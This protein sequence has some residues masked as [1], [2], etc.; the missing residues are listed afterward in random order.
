MEFGS[1]PCV[2]VDGMRLAQTRAIDNY[3]GSK[4]KMVPEDTLLV[5]KGEKMVAYTLGDV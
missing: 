3:L 4:L 1:L 2:D 5:H